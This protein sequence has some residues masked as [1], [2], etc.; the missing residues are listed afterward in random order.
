MNAL[1]PSCFAEKLTKRQESVLGALQT[2]LTEA[3]EM[4]NNAMRRLDKVTSRRRE[5]RNERLNFAR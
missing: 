2:I 3:Q 4:V 5:R 1:E